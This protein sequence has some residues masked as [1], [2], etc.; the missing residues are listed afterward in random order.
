MT[1]IIREIRAARHPNELTD[2]DSEDDE[3]A[4]KRKRQKSRG[5]K[6]RV[7]GMAAVTEA[8]LLEMPELARG[9]LTTKTLTRHETVLQRMHMFYPWAPSVEDMVSQSTTALADLAAKYLLERSKTKIAW[10][11]LETEGGTIMGALKRRQRDISNEA[12]MKDAMT[13]IK[14]N[15]AKEP[16]AWPMVFTPGE[17]HQLITMASGELKMFLVMAFGGAMRPSDLFATSPVDTVTSK[18]HVSILVRGGKQSKERP[19]AV[20]ILTGAFHSEVRWFVSK[21]KAERAAYHFED[22]KEFRNQIRSYIREV[23]PKASL[24]SFRSTTLITMGLMGASLTTIQQLATHTSLGTT[25][26]YLRFGVANAGAASAQ[27]G[28]AMLELLG[29]VRDDPGDY[30]FNFEE[31]QE[32]TAD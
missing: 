8:K 29:Q 19:K 15:A 28:A 5:G 24:R 7:E 31:D 12:V 21:K 30:Y 10:S 17:V 14:R 18:S 2:D 3:E 6:W 4:K 16:I 20:H 9:A 13:T 22:T 25:Q 26:R 32:Q 1:R 23:C 11:T 27:K